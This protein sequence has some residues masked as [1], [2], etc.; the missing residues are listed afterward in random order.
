M[1]GSLVYTTPASQAKL[2]IHL[3][4]QLV[5]LSTVAAVASAF[6]YTGGFFQPL[7]ASVRT[8]GCTG[9]FRPDIRA[10]DHI[11]VYWV[12]P[13]TAAILTTFLKQLI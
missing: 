2:G 5:T 1:I 11:F 4:I 10:C 6:Y 9:Y 7:L 3:G 13:I 12:G 8:F